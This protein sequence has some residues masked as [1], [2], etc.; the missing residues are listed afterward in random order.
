VNFWIRVGPI[1]SSVSTDWFQKRLVVHR[2]SRL[3]RTCDLVRSDGSPM[4]VLAESGSSR[5]YLP[6]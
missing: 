2:S 1:S 3:T 4:A 5:G 6:A